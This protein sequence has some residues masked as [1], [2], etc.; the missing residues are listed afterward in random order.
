[1]KHGNARI[2]WNPS[3]E[4][5]TGRPKVDVWSVGCILYEMWTAKAALRDHHGTS[6]VRAK[7]SR[8]LESKVGIHITAEKSYQ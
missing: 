4:I 7:R 3:R 5:T 1:L 8:E 6:S 2:Q